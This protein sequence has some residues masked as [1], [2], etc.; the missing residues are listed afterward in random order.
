MIHVDPSSSAANTNLEMID[1]IKTVG[2]DL[3]SFLRHSLFGESPGQLPPKENLYRSRYDFS[4][5]DE[6]YKY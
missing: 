1:D 2:N 5:L 3:L 4:I 6:P